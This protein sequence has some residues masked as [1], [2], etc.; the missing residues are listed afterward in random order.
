[1][2]RLAQEHHLDL[3]TIVGSGLGGRITRDDV[4][5]V[6]NG[7]APAAAA[8]APSEPAQ[9]V[10]AA[11]PPAPAPVPVGEREELLRH[12]TMRRSIAERMV[13]SVVTAPQAWTMVEVDVTELVRYRETQ[14]ASIIY[15]K[16]YNIGIAVALDWGLIVPV[17]KNANDLSLSGLTKS[18]ND[19]AER[20]RAKRLK[21]EEVRDGTFTLN[22]T[23]ANGS[24]LS[25]P[26][27]NEPQTGILTTEAIVRRPVVVG[28]DAIAVR[29][30]MNL[31]LTF[32]HRVIDGGAAGDFMNTMKR[33]LERWTPGDLRI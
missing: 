12:N 4:L 19:L 31:C 15:R 22:N 11:T 14:K 24:I 6:V 10:P 13:H 3:T 29:H 27:L 20:A 2:R 21:P 26:I 28:D 17:I 9:A 23:G 25:R 7:E 33:R 5:A 18:L 30:I 1:V 32:D 16:P 8:A